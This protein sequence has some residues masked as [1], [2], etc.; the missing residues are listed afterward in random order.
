MLLGPIIIGVFFMVIGMIVSARLK[1][2]FHK[3]SQ[4]HL[5]A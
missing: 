3:Y 1:S 2:K 4:V 5:D